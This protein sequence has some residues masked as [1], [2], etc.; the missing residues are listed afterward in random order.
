M[1]LSATQ[2]AWDVDDLLCEAAINAPYG[3]YGHLRETDPVHFNE[4]WNGWIVT[5]YEHVAAGYRDHVRLS[6]DRFEGPFAEEWK[7]GGALDS[8]HAALFEFLSHFFVWKDPPYH[9]RVRELVGAAFSA[10]EVE[11]WRPRIAQLVQEL[12]AP[13]RDRD[14]AD[15]LGEFAFHLPVIVI[16][17]YLGVPVEAR[18]QIKLWSD[19]LGGV[20]F[21]RGDDADR[22]ANAERAVREL[23]EFLRPILEARR[24]DP[25]DDLIT[26]MLQARTPDGDALTDEEIIGNAILMVFAGHETTMNLLANSIVAFEEHPDQWQLLTS[27]PDLAR[28]AAEE[29]LRYDGPIR[30]MARWAREPVDLGPRQ[31]ATNDRVLLVQAAANRDPA[32]FADPDVLDITRR[33]NR[34]LT[35]GHGIHTCLGGPLARLETQEALRCLSQDFAR[36]EVTTDELR[37]APTIVSRGLRELH[38]RFH[39]R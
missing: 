26:G 10:R 9:T 24:T 3:F 13:L 20:I 33:P 7:A 1:A 25:R 4:R 34:Q 2:P 39:E 17:E 28:S 21:V 16:A 29:C 6:S 11:Q 19:D 22:L 14:D 30:A 27:R 31:I 38:V 23:E 5:S 35:F 36:I 15:F 37:Y 32:T 8:S 18:Q 12:I